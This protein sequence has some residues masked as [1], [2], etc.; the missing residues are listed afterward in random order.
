MLRPL[1]R[2]KTLCSII[3]E[4]LL[5]SA[6]CPALWLKRTLLG[7]FHLS[8]LSYFV[9]LLL[10][11]PSGWVPPLSMSSKKAIAKQPPAESSVLQLSSHRSPSFVP[12]LLLYR[13]SSSSSSHLC[14]S[15]PLPTFS[16]PFLFTPPFVSRF[17]S[18]FP[19]LTPPIFLN[20]VCQGNSLLH[21]PHSFPP[22]AHSPLIYSRAE[23]QSKGTARLVPSARSLAWGKHRGVGAEMKPAQAHGCL[24]ESFLDTCRF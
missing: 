8:F 23:L 1:L 9:L 24:S 2:C 21:F 10:S 13:E 11:A 19:T 16:P 18:F 20:P 4:L 14:V 17:I 15:A 3:Q 12:P 6:A 7:C 22:S 5:S